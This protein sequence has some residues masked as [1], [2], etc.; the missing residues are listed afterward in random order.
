MT[1]SKFGVGANYAGL[2]GFTW[3]AGLNPETFNIPHKKR[4]ITYDKPYSDI[5]I[6]MS[7]G[8]MVTLIGLRGE[9][10]TESDFN[11][12]RNQ[13]KKTVFDS[14]NEI[15]D[16]P[17]KVYLDSST[18][19]MWVFGDEF[20]DLRNS[21]RQS[22]WPYQV[23]L[24]MLHPFYYH[25][26]IASGTNTTTNTSCVVTGADIDNDGKAYVFPYFEIINNT[27]ADITKITV[28][29]GTNTLI[30]EADTG[31]ELGA[32]ESVRLIQEDNPDLELSEW[33]AYKYLTDDFSDAAVSQIGLSGTLL[34]I[35]AETGGGAN[36]YTFTLTGNNNTATCNVKFR[37]RDK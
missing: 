12:L 25:D 22:S 28:T 31:E 33:T 24:M 37:E 5:S 9:L 1:Q 2:S 11:D 14:V 34:R 21:N 8:S 26:T 16:A 10:F 17:Q 19:F 20:L 3:P 23:N 13:V 29:D 30:W 35:P 15:T 32:G 6:N 4:N 27:G 7:A 18:K 36:S